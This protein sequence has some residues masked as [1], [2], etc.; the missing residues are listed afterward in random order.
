MHLQ[1]RQARN[2][3]AIALLENDESGKSNENEKPSKATEANTNQ[4]KMH[5]FVVLI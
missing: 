3:A 4:I 1:H 2:K 5:L